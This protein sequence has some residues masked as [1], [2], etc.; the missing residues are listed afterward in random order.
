MLNVILLIVGLG[1]IL[2]G[3]NYLTDGAAAI[4]KRFGLSDL[5]V[6]LTVVAF[7]TSA[8]ELTISVIS[9]IDGSGGMAIG[10]V[11]GSNIFNIL[12]IVGVVAL[13]R[14]IIVEKSIMTNEIP[15]VVLSCAA[16]VAIYCGRWLDG[17]ISELTRVDGI[18]LLLFFA[19]F[20]RYVWSQAHKAENE[21]GGEDLKEG[22]E[23]VEKTQKGG[24]VKAMVMTFGGLAALVWGGDI[25]VDSASGIARGLGVSDAVIGLTIVALGTSAP[26]FA[27]S[28]TAAL[29]GNSGMA[30]GN[31]IG[32]NIFNILLVLGVS[33]TVHPLTFGGVTP[34]DMGML[35]GSTLLFWLFGWKFRV[36]TITRVEGG[37]MAAV[38][39]GYI[40]WLI[41]NA[42]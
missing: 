35:L 16:L 20:M 15:L 21:G 36:R 13:C 39:I 7:G 28:V 23:T 25:F 1:M 17:G 33:G 3:A 5:V 31:V 10:N 24:L 27:A 14:P 8:P 42:V 30:V 37:V 26:E 19:I 6:G 38:Y 29:K 18:L 9:A 40:T 11:V 34:V 2:G 32:S 41:I 12:M 22:D 4:A